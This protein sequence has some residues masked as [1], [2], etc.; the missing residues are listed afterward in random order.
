MHVE[1]LRVQDSLGYSGE[2][3]INE[4]RKKAK[5]AP[6]ASKSVT[7]KARAARAVMAAQDSRTA[8]EKQVTRHTQVRKK[9]IMMFGISGGTYKMCMHGSIC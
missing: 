3:L 2:I 7:A 6:V 8:E 1:G 4:S 9:K 5:T